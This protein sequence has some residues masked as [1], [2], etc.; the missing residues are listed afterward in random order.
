MSAVAE[1]EYETFAPQ[2][3]AAAQSF[4][5]QLSNLS[6]TPFEQRPVEN[7]PFSSPAS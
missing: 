7:W 1:R 4:C 6:D 2:V 3:V 5:D